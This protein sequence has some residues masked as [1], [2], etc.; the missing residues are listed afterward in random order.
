MLKNVSVS[1]PALRTLVFIWCVVSVFLA[2]TAGANGDQSAQNAHA[3]AAAAASAAAL[4]RVRRQSFSMIQDL[5]A[6]AEML[7]EASH[8]RRMQNAL[9]FFN[10]LRKR[11]P[12]AG[13][14]TRQTS[15]VDTEFDG[16]DNDVGGRRELAPRR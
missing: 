3:A 2:I 4:S 13:V 15:A 16:I 8:R 9:A 1:R 6:L 11:S 7:R 14:A 10:A 5:D 12:D